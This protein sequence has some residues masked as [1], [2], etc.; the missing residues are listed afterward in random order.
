MTLTGC[1][2]RPRWILD[3]LSRHVTEPDVFPIVVLTCNVSAYWWRNHGGR[4]TKADCL[5]RM[6]HTTWSFD[7][8]RSFLEASAS[9]FLPTATPRPAGPGG[10]CHRRRLL[11]ALVR[12]SMFAASKAPT[13]LSS[14]AYFVSAR[15]FLDTLITVFNSTMSAL[16]P[17][18]YVELFSRDPQR[19]FVSRSWMVIFFLPFSNVLCTL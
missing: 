16:P 9:R 4:L 13:L 18:R 19:Q 6:T 1:V 12:A 2:A 8:K 17:H 3:L 7:T 15:G 5:L 10:C 11:P 14:K